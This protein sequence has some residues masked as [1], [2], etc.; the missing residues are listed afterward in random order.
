M[1]SMVNK[2]KTSHSAKPMAKVQ[3][4]FFEK[5][6]SVFTEN[7]SNDLADDLQ[8]K[9]SF[10]DSSKYRL[11]QETKKLS[12]AWNAR[13]ILSL[14]SRPN[15]KANELDIIAAL[16]RNRKNSY[17][18]HYSALYYNDQIQ[19][20]PKDF[21]ISQAIKHQYPRDNKPINDLLVMQSFMKAPRKSNNYFSYNQNSFYLLEKEKQALV[22]VTTKSLH[23]E[24]GNIALKVTDL[25]RTFIDC[26]M[27]PQYSGGLLTVVNVFKNLDLNIRTLK[28]YYDKINPIYPFWQSIGL[29]L[30]KNFP[31]NLSHE[32]EKL[33]SESEKKTFFLDHN[34]KSHWKLSSRW[35]VHYP[36]GVFEH[37][38][39][40]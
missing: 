32:W 31:P 19:Q 23:F 16:L 13:R 27:A 8:E 25:E 28:S 1:R 36:N 33:F 7:E 34:Y 9:Y 40:Q 6:P 39:N 3:K 38:N 11:L 12:L 37:D 30:E 17:L 5:L 29:I 35:S 20:K 24:K 4:E 14:Y 15:Y 22:G 26:I 10:S 18:S 21:Y 2:E